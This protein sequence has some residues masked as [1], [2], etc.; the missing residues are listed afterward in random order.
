[1]LRTF[2][3]RVKGYLLGINIFNPTGK[4]G[5]A[6]FEYS[7]ELSPEIEE[8]IDEAVDIIKKHI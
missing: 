1:M 6:D 4:N 5:N 7:M 3:I 8:K 2:K